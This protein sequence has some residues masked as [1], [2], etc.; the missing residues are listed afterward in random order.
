MPANNIQAT[1]Q[2][3]KKSTIS[4]STTENK[5]EGKVCSHRI[6]TKQKNILT[7]QGE[8]CQSSLV[9]DSELKNNSRITHKKESQENKSRK[10]KLVKIDDP[11]QVDKISKLVAK[12]RK[13]LI[14]SGL[15][16][17]Y[18]EFQDED[19]NLALGFRLQYM[20]KDMIEEN[21]E[22][23]NQS[24][25]SENSFYPDQRNNKSERKPLNL[26]IQSL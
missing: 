25:S 23:G 18:D 10:F 13:S 2:S 5:T 7:I 14:E 12:K 22:S 11:N 3:Q 15:S 8:K 9:I 26:I 19:I 17:G 20:L 16:E 24:N 21:Q 4:L 6:S 1:S